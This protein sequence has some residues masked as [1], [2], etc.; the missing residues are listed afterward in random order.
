MTPTPDHP[1]KPWHR[2]IGLAAPLAV[3]AAL[4]LAGL[5]WGYYACYPGRMGPAQP[6]AFS[7]RLH[8][9]EKQISC[10]FCHTGVVDTERAGVPPLETCILCH[11]HII[12]TYP[13][14]VE[15]RRYYNE[16]LPLRWVR[17]NTLPEFVFFN[18]EVHVR[19]GFDCGRCHGD[20]ARM[21]RV[22]LEQDFTMGFCVQCHRDE[23]FSHDCLICHR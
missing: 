11:R 16:G 3:L 12:R 5:A 19:R 9:A 21:D 7:H 2:R 17:V 4:A 15:L 23:T 20:V 6:I 13:A 8:V 1:K 14:V 18:H 10:V 22:R